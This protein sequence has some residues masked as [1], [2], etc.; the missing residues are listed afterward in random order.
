MFDEVM[1]HNHIITGPKRDHQVVAPQLR[2]SGAVSTSK[3]QAS[4]RQR[5]TR[6]L[7][8]SPS[9]RSSGETPRGVA[10]KSLLED[11]HPSMIQ[12]W[13]MV[14]MYNM[15]R[16]C[17]QCISLFKCVCPLDADEFCCN[18]HQKRIH[19]L[20]HELQCTQVSWSLKKGRKPSNSWHI[21]LS[22]AKNLDQRHQEIMVAIWLPL[23]KYHLEKTS[24][25]LFLVKNL[26]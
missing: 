19:Y 7:R 16:Y 14:D 3:L 24:Q 5:H 10:A 13:S 8:N 6:R 25:Y 12:W 1:I 21:F 11:D 2:P 15:C 23:A 4:P 17:N 18:W 26:M 22:F 20:D 9:R